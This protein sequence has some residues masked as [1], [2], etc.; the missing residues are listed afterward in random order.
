MMLG[1]DMKLRRSDHILISNLL[2][3]PNYVGYRKRERERDCVFLGFHF[4]SRTHCIR[5]KIASHSH[6][7]QKI[8]FSCRMRQQR[9]RERESVSESDQKRKS[10]CPTRKKGKNDKSLCWQ[11]ILLQLHDFFFNSNYV[12]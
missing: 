8:Q 10:N 11:K 9:E 5:V 2:F 3:T 12:K 6:K 4:I 1:R 7:N